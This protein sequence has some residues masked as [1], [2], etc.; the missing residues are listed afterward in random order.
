MKIFP[1]GK[2]YSYK[3]NEEHFFNLGMADR[4]GCGYGHGSVFNPGS[5]SGAGIN[6]C[7]GTGHGT[8]RGD[9]KY[10]FNLILYL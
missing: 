5:G 7:Y 8:G 4:I 1:N 10:P 2:Q 3:E 9:G 6:Y